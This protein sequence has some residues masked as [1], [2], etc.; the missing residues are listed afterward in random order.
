MSTNGNNT[1]DNNEADKSKIIF[2]I[3]YAKLDKK[4]SK[5]LGKRLERSVY[6]DEY[7]AKSQNKNATS[8]YWYFRKSNFAGVN[9]IFFW[10]I[11][12]KM[13]IDKG[14]KPKC[15]IYQKV[16]SEILK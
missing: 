4:L 7:L 16:L 11:Q 1:A 12:T 2:D 5:L 15:I 13:T 3:K 14:I 9:R 10:L 6:W 8:N